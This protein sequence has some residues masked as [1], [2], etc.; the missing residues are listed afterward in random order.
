M[1]AI[2]GPDVSR[3]VLAPEQQDQ[4]VMVAHQSSG[5]YQLEGFGQQ[6]LLVW[7]A[8]LTVVCHASQR[9][10]GSSDAA[11][12]SKREPSGSRIDIGLR[13]TPSRLTSHPT[14]RGVIGRG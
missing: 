6:L 5:G 7:R 1:P 12:I 4:P 11:S 13:V 8:Q 3:E 9:I 14:M 2:S 10:G